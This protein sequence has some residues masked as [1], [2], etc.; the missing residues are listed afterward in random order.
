MKIKNYIFLVFLT[1]KFQFPTQA[2]R[3]FFLANSNE[4]YLKFI[5]L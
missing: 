2:F 5:Q 3:K 4:S 1:E